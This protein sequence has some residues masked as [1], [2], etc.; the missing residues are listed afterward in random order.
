M[1]DK[2]ILFQEGSN[3]AF[4]FYMFTMDV[5]I[6]L[7]M[8]IF[9]TRFMRKPPDKINVV[10]TIRPCL[11]KNKETWEFAHKYCGK[12]WLIC[13]LIMFLVTVI[14]ML[15]MTKKDVV[16]IG[17]AGAI[18]VGIQFAH[19]ISSVFLTERALRRNFDKN[20]S[21]SKWSVPRQPMADKSINYYC[22]TVLV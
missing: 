9:G 18:I 4:W 1:V 11:W 20:G 10:L 7:A 12:L 2:I 3:M 15:T 14:I 8:I 19:L 16:T 22:H 21:S 5:F 6:T 17:T 13:G